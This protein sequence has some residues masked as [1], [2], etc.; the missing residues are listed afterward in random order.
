MWVKL[1]RLISHNVVVNY[2]VLKTRRLIQFLRHL[3]LQ[4]LYYPKH[5]LHFRKIKFT[6][7]TACQLPLYLILTYLAHL[8]IIHLPLLTKG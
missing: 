2:L 5:I 4:N 3:M 8:F 1:Y 7:Y 6:G